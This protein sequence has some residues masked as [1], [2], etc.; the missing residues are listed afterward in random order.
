MGE[1]KKENPKHTQRRMSA[2][3]KRKFIALAGLAFLCALFVIGIFYSS[4]YRYVHRMDREQIEQ[5]V[6]VQGVDI[7]GMTEKEALE[8][9]E[10]RWT[11]MKHMP[12]T[13]KAD[14]KTAQVTVSELGI[15]QG[16]LVSLVK[17]ASEYGKHGNLYQ[18][19]RK[20]RQAKKEKVEYED[21]YQ[22]DEETAEK[23]LEE[24]TADFFEEA[25]NAKIT[26]VGG[27]FQIT[28]E[29][30][31]EK[32]AVQD[33]LDEIVDRLGDLEKGK[34]VEIEVKSEKDEPNISRDDLE[35]V[36]DELGSASVE[37]RN[38]ETRQELLTL[39][40]D[41]NG[42]IVMPEKEL[43]LQKVLE[44]HSGEEMSQEAL[45]LMAT[46]LYD[47]ALYAETGISERHESETIP[48]Y[49]DAG[50]EAVLSEEKD[51][52]IENTTESPL[53]IEAYINGDEELVCTIYGEETRD[54]E[55]SISF[56]T[57]TEEKEDSEVATVYEEDAALA[58]GKT[59]VKESGSP[60]STVTLLKIVKEDG[61]KSDEE[62]VGASEYDAVSRIVSVG[63]KTDDEKTKEALKEA[64]ATQDQE[65]IERAVEQARNSKGQER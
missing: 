1:R 7:S 25:V 2:A 63:I 10:N 8:K 23:V 13:L 6:F 38:D 37:I 16:D 64:V 3:Q 51:L 27:V 55:R 36:Q 15:R 19:Y 46:S 57:E 5:N 58:A 47:A 45:D 61:E 35:A 34:D 53:Y 11:V 41:L 52:K 17:E 20:I 50:M 39:T 44:E 60:E 56:K 32:A 29:K 21:D 59:E 28:D 26:R 9:L 4:V 48:E 40:G 62:E 42:Q 31:G 65:T 49:V 30:D 12:V 54:E 33:V 24:K 14:G 22:I 18:R 43:S